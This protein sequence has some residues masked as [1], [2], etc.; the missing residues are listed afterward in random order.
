[1]R[2]LLPARYGPLV[3]A[4]TGSVSQIHFGVYVPN[5][6]SFGSP[7]VLAC[8]AALTEHSGWDGFFIWD[9]LVMDDEPIADAQITL[10]A[11][12]ERTTKIR[13]GALVTPVARR[14]PWK[15]ARE[16][17]SLDQLAP[18]RLIL[19]VGLGMPRDFAPFSTEPQK[20]AQRGAALSDGLDLLRRFLTGQ[21]VSWSQPSKTATS[22]PTNL[23]V[24]A[25]SFRPVPK[26][27]VPIWGAGRIQRCGA[28]QRRA[29]FARAKNLAGLFPVAS[30]WNAAKPLT[31]EELRLAVDLT[32][33]GSPAPHGYEVVTT[34]CTQGSGAVS[35]LQ[36]YVDA[37]A[38]WWLELLPDQMSEEQARA[39]IAAGPPTLTAPTSA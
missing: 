5:Y 24:K 20:E 6:G 7:T 14:R 22:H 16:V 12:A 3:P 33:E 30:E 15:L 2:A 37:G 4:R 29:P 23:V 35:D 10:A 18:D 21:Q 26:N 17:A 39:V 27:P 11:I 32:F 9:H 8:L 36:A 1:M 38:T 31:P 25:P 28:S 19:G 34:G 13:I